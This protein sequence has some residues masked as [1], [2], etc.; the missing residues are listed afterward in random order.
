MYFDRW[1]IITA[2][3]LFCSDYHSGL[4]SVEYKR[5]CKIGKYF[6]PGPMFG[7]ESLTD[8]ALEIYKQLEQK[9]LKQGN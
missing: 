4:W 7:P 5:L 3:Y 9:E 8:N 2:Y 1:D 6:T